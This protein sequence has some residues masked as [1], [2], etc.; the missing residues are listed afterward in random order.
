MTSLIVVVD[1]SHLDFLAGGGGRRS[2][3]TITVTTASTCYD[4]AHTPRHCF[5]LLPRHL[6]SAENKQFNFTDGLGEIFKISKISI[7]CSAG[8]TRFDTESTVVRR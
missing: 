7:R 4:P 3:S 1:L 8:Q 5:V 2:L 6:S